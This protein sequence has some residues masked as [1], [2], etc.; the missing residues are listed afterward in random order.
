MSNLEKTFERYVAAE[1]QLCDEAAPLLGAI[2]RGVEARLGVRISELRVT[3]DW[4]NSVD[5]AIIANCTIVQGQRNRPFEPLKAIERRGRFRS[6]VASAVSNPEFYAP[7]ERVAQ[8]VGARPCGRSVS[9]SLDLAYPFAGAASGA[10]ASRRENFSIDT[11][12][13]PVVA[14]W[15]TQYSVG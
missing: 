3:V 15:R 7:I 10:L 12:C 11:E 1:R 6:N 13:S 2:I 5:G 4:A 8:I 9:A 14:L